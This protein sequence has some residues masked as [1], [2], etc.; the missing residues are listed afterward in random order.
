MRLC[1]ICSWNIA[2]CNKKYYTQFVGRIAH[3]P[4]I[5]DFACALSVVNIFKK[6]GL[7]DIVERA[8]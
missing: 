2:R 5:I 3:Q 1:L 7:E 6:T 8:R 4:R